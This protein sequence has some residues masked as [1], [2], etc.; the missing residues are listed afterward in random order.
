[1][2]PEMTLVETRETTPRHYG[3]GLTAGRT[4]AVTTL[5]TLR[6]MA[7]RGYISHLRCMLWLHCAPI[8][9]VLCLCLL[10]AVFG[11]CRSPLANPIFE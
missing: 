6:N 9:I 4:V 11:S 1:M 5:T 8:V 2:L 7:A 10:M 3:V